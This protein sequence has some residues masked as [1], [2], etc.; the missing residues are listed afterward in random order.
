MISL[1]AGGRLMNVNFFS[2]HAKAMFYLNR[3]GSASGHFRGRSPLS[4]RSMGQNPLYYFDNNATTRV[5]PEVIEAMLPF[6]QEH[7]GNPS[8]AYSFSKHVAQQL[9]LA[10]EQVAALINAEPKEVV[11]TSCGTESN[12]TAIHSALALQPTKRHIIMTAVEH[13]ANLNYG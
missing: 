9:D 6:L 3:C 11:F 4:E 2:F 7:W 10:R 5:A 1:S 12:N 13:S 8:S